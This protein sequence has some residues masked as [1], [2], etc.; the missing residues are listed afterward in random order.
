MKVSIA[1]PAYLP[2]LGYFARIL[3]SDLHV[4]L[5]D[6]QHSK[7][8]FTNRNKLRTKQGWQ[9]VTVP[10]TTK[11]KYTSLRINELEIVHTQK[12]ELKHLRAIKDNYARAPFLPL[13]S[14]FFQQVYGSEWRYLIELT[15]RTNAFFREQLG[16][17]TR[18]LKSSDIG[19][20]AKKDELILNI[21][22]AVGAN[23]YLS[24]PFGRD[25]L[26]ED[27]FRKAGIEIQYHD[28]RHPV[29]IQAFPGFEPNMSVVDLL[30]NCGPDSREVLC[31]GNEACA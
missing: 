9:W 23:V 6:V 10:V 8:D 27:L 19:C 4:V 7:R 20:D 1:Q 13:Y 11:G 31:R 30:C 25:Y 2:W 24:G 16:I 3:F 5:D 22:Q 21:C 17:T 18:V 15:D 12:W 28:Y 26:R 14:E 29:Y